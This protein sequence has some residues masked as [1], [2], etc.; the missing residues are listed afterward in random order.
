MISMNFW[1][2]TPDVF[3]NF[4]IA[5]MQFL[6]INAMWNNL[7]KNEQEKI[8]KVLGVYEKELGKL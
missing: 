3:E 7:T 1:G 8:D 6:K 4:K 5:Y 2:F